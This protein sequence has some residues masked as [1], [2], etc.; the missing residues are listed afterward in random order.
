[1]CGIFGSINNNAI[2]DTY[3]GLSRLEYRGYDSFGYAA[4]RDDAA[5]R[6]ESCR[7]F[8]GIGTL[9]P[10]HT[11]TQTSAV[12]G[13]VRWATN[14]KVTTNNAHPQSH[15]EI[16]VVHNGVIENA[17]PDMLDTKWLAELI[18][19]RGLTETLSAID[20]DNSF[21]FIDS[22]DGKIWCAAKG[23]KRLFVTPNG[24]VSS[25][26]NALSGFSTEAWVISNNICDLSFGLS[27]GVERVP[28]PPLTQSE[29]SHDG[30][31]MLKEIGEQ[32][33][34]E[35]TIWPTV[36]RD[37]DIIAT[38]SSLHAAM[39]GAYALEG[40]GV[41]GVRCLHASQAKYRSLRDNILAISQSGETKDV[42]NALGGKDFS[43]I[44]N[45]PYSTLADM[46]SGC[47]E[48]GTGPEIAVAATKTFTSSCMK[49]CQ[50]AGIKLPDGWQSHAL[51]ILLRSDEIKEIARSIMGYEHF[52]FL[53]DRHN[54]PIALEGALKFKEVAYVHAEGMPASEMK[55]GPIA[56][57]DHRVPS[58]FIVSEGF[59]KETMTNIQEIK[60]R[61][62]FV[63]VIT[64]NS[65]EEEFIG[66]GVD[67]VFS[68]GDTG[69]KYSQSLVLNF[70]LQL[71]SYYVAV[72]RGI[73]PDRPRNLAKCVTV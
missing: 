57:V 26:I 46:S 27:A 25:D 19:Q 73:N 53:G 2:R 12:I 7:V 48:M 14:G 44:T 38:G 13:H 40:Q 39:F 34:L 32:S 58:L 23:S 71:L 51:S 70:V 29:S 55:H 16:H 52:L 37:L 31:K 15:G 56:L 28:V 20:G 60:S 65:I 50:S 36:E 9:R 43:C 24:Y 17:P 41:G 42:I 66:K 21:V 67:I 47:V 69:E 5:F 64:H 10:W 11:D 22:S 6:D 30:H 72:N 35:S 1:M 54:Y 4:Y 63:V 18:S 68:C 33:Q 49:L 61:R 59:S 62:G 3:E 8:R 45:N